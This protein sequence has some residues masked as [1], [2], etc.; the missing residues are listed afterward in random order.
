MSGTPHEVTRGS[1]S[2]F[3]TAI[4]ETH[5]CFIDDKS[6]A[7]LGYAG[8]VAPPTYSIVVAMQLLEGFLA[9]DGVPLSRVM[10]TGQSFRYR[11]PIVAGDVL[12]GVLDVTGRKPFGGNELVATTIT[13]HSGDEVVVECG[14]T[15]LIAAP[16]DS[17]TAPKPAGPPP[18]GGRSVSAGAPSAQT[19]IGEL[20]TYDVLVTRGDLVRYAG[21]SGDFNAIHYSGAAAQA[22]GLPDVIA[23]GMLT[24]ALA[25]RS[26]TATL[27]DP[28][29]LAA[30]STK[31]TNPVVVPDG[32]GATVT[33][34]GSKRDAAT[35]A[36]TAES[37]GAKV[38]NQTRAVIR[39]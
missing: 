13:V 20:P 19:G 10:H 28:A 17:A 21:A 38:L 2:A 23:H 22:L 12:T 1:I 3:V 4:G 39:S 25:A 27:A 15:V 30:L 8:L 33:F 14:A 31:F 35:L 11:R 36:I 26:A 34:G 37:G 5:P 6:A 9:S 24:L 7:E 18:S 32:V 16:A 29:R